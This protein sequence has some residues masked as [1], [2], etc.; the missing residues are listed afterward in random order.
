MAGQFNKDDPW[1]CKT[2]ESSRT[3]SGVC[4]F[5]IEMKHG[6]VFDKY[7][8]E[9]HAAAYPDSYQHSGLTKWDPVSIITDLRQSKLNQ[10]WHEFLLDEDIS[11][12]RNTVLKGAERIVGDDGYLRAVKITNM[13]TPCKTMLNFLVMTRLPY[14]FPKHVEL[15]RLLVSKG[16]SKHAAMV[17]CHVFNKSSDTT[18]QLVPFSPGHQ[19]MDIDHRGPA[20]QP[21]VKRLRDANPADTGGPYK[22][23]I[24]PSGFS[25]IWGPVGK[26]DNA[27]IQVSA[28]VKNKVELR[29]YTGSFPAMFRKIRG[30]EMFNL[31]Q[32]NNGGA[33][34]TP[35]NIDDIVS[36]E[37]LWS[38][39]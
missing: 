8:G 9:C 31:V 1:Q 18:C 21:S 24:N 17:A 38:A 22:K 4:S 23:L 27:R 6:Y 15:W 3:Y 10:D 35:Y 14:E 34:Q 26:N 11:P 37:P 12:Y 32:P 25:A 30:Q 29:M 36:S 33:N 39:L 16:V 28:S 7:S 2:P 13:D 5:R 20:W 19:A